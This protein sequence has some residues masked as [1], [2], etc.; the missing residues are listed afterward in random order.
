ML[1]N[2]NSLSVTCGI[3]FYSRMSVSAMRKHF[4]RYMFQMPHFIF[5]TLTRCFQ[6]ILDFCDR[7]YW[8]VLSEQEEAGKEQSECTS[9]ET[10][11]PDGWTV[12]NRPAR[13]KIISVQRGN[14]DHETLEPHTN[15]YDDTHEESNK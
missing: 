13:W 3:I 9:V 1:F 15:I 5:I 8:E 12:V 14:D 10:N 6:Y 4:H 7:N 11:F 2:L